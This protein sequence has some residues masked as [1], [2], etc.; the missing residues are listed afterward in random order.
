M[1]CIEERERPTNHSGPSIVV[2]AF[3]EVGSIR[4]ATESLLNLGTDLPHEILVVDDD[5][6][7]GIPDLARTLAQA[8]DED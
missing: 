3:N 8:D 6:R 5:S 1:K 7:D 4:P 2:P